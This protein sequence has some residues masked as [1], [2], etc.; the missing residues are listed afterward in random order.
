[1]SDI[2]TTEPLPL[3]PPAEIE[4]DGPAS[5]DGKEPCPECGDLYFRGPGLARHMSTQH[6]LPMNGKS[7]NCPQ[8]DKPLSPT[9]LSKHLRAKHG[10]F[11]RNGRGRPI[12]SK[13]KVH[14]PVVH[15]QAKPRITRQPLRAEEIT[16]AAALSLW[17]NAIPHDKMSLLLEWHR[18]TA[19]FLEAVQGD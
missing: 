14:T 5:N 2:L 19:E 8:C 15:Q 16:R 11:Q 6:G 17:P 3:T 7:V 12:G 4:V 18:H 10:I 13:T 9:S 1:M